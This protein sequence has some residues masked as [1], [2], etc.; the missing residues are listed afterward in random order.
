MNPDVQA[1]EIV[2]GLVAPAGVDLGEPE[3]IISQ[4]LA[5]AGYGTNT[6]R[7]STLIKS[8]KGLD[9]ELMEE[10]YAERLRTYMDGG[11]RAR[12]M[13][14]RGDVL[15]LSAAVQI[16]DARSAASSEAK[17]AYIIRSFKHPEEA[18][19]LRHIYGKGFFL[20][21]VHARHDTR[22]Q[23]LVSKRSV[24]PSV[25]AEIIERDALEGPEY[26]QRVRDVFH[27]ADAFVS[28]D[29]ADAH[30]Q[31]E[32]VMDLLFG[33]PHRTP[34][35]EEHAM[36][37]AFG[38]ALRSGDLSRQVGAVIAN[39]FG[40]ILATGTNDA[41]CP[42]GG[43]YWGEDREAMRD[44]E[45]GHDSNQRERNHIIVEVMR[46]VSP[47]GA[48]DEL[49]SSGLAQLKHT[50][51][52]DITEYGRAVHAE[53]AALMSCARTGAPTLN[54]TVYCTTFPCHNCAKHI[55]CAGISR[56][57]FIEPYPKSKALDLHG[58]AMG[59]R[60]GAVPDKKVVFEPFI[61]IAPRRFVDLF[62]ME[63]GSGKSILRKDRHSGDSVGFERSTAKP[64]NCLI[65]YSHLEL[66][67]AAAVLLE[68]ATGGRSDVG[69]ED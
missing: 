17:R 57:V 3:R 60:N 11:T 49:L 45:R 22:L 7:M 32:R 18:H 51:L 67:E 38:S 54:A 27:L 6:T 14:R 56:V 62:A 68:N 48:D 30:Q 25:A 2:I 33:H 13:N 26:G 42:G 24:A 46:Q 40:D 64:R 15:A 16:A 41:P 69:K 63:L 4:Y 37:M 36:Y 29:G 55:I 39:T 12:A 58:D 31:M 19:T 23:Y 5:D 53:M 66:E 52:L 35:R 59:L 20:I 10:P 50:G 34:T 43:Q 44:C 9:V 8:V 65:P 1:S 21:G 28:V 47:N 61:G